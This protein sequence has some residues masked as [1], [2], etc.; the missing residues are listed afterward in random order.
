ML[1]ETGV[2]DYCTGDVAPG[3]FV[4]VKTD[5]PY[6]AHEMSYLGMGPGPYFSLYRPYHLASVEAATTIAEMLVENKASFATSSRMTEV[7]AMTKKDHANG[8]KLD[9]I[10]GYS[11][12]AFAD[13]KEDALRD[14][15]VPIGLLQGATVKREL[16]IDKLVTWDDVDIDESQTIVALRREMESLGL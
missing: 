12:R 4:I 8:D 9:G 13:R 11:M 3:V 6:V 15:L 10:G 1:E 16:P 5:K 2:V 7:V 14:N